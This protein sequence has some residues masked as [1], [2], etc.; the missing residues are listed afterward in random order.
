MTNRTDRTG[1]APWR[2][3]T[4]LA[5]ALAAL[6]ALTLPGVSA[7]DGGANL[8]GLTKDDLQREGYVC[9]FYD[10][11]GGV[12][13]CTRDTTMF[14]CDKDGRN[15]VQ[16][17]LPGSPLTKDDLE[18]KGYKCQFWA[19]SGGTVICTKGESTYYCDKV[20]KDC[21]EG[22]RLTGIRGTQW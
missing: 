17:P 21:K 5:V 19:I 16:A 8:T 18:A 10:I 4:I 11:N 20:G 12:V 22:P 14:V 15:C 1:K 7:A 6:F 9:E 3:W 13:I 2:L